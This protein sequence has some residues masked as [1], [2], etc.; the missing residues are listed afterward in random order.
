HWFDIETIRARDLWHLTSRLTRK[1]LAHNV[2]VLLNRSNGRPALHF[3]D[4]IT[5]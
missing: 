5:Q 3:A 2:M 1:I 4:I